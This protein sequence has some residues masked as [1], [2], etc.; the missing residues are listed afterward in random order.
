MKRIAV[1]ALLSS[2]A[3]PAV[4]ADFYAGIRAGQAKTSIDNVTLTK[5]SSTGWGIFGGY[6]FNPNFAVE[7]EYINLGKPE[8]APDSFETDGFSAAAVG[9]WPVGEQFSIFGKLG[10]AMLTTKGP[11]P[12]DA[13]SNTV[14]FGI[15]GQFDVNPMMGF[16][17]GWDRYKLDDT[18]NGFAVK[19]DVDLIS[20][21]ALFRF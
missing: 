19:G 8:V 14:T 9:T 2:L 5:D 12:P 21:G 16:R 13:E 3:I 4:A 1:A 20:V 15:G 7:L 10:F 18:V 6:N 11:T 17:L